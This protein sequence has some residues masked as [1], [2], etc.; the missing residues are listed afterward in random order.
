MYKQF[1]RLKKKNPNAKTL[2]AVGGWS[3]ASQP[4]TA[5]V[6]SKESRR[7]FIIHAIRY[8]RT[9]NFDGLDLDWEYPANRGSPP[10]DKQR[11]VELVKSFFLSVRLCFFLLPFFFFLSFFL[12]FFIFYLILSVFL[13]F[14][15][16][17]FFLS[18]FLSFFLS[19]FLRTCSCSSSVFT[20]LIIY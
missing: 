9:H 17:S 13:S 16:L 12:S 7:D 14:Y 2:L 6:R 10:E 20:Y 11:F 18:L 4:F 19:F 8:L 15:F 1:T 3:M 5:M